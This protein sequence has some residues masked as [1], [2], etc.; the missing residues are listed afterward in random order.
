M[1]PSGVDGL[2]STSLTRLLPTQSLWSYLSIEHAGKSVA[3]F[4][5]V[6]EVRQIPG[7]TCRGLR[8]QRVQEK[9]PV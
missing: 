9:F 6:R 7:L 8:S 4:V 3:Y 2:G 1:G 5:M